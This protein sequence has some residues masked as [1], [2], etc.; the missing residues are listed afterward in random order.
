MAFIIAKKMCDFNL[1]DKFQLEY[2]CCLFL[3]TDVDKINCFSKFMRHFIDK[4]IPYTS[5]LEM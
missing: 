2:N 4:I 1:D 3:I 5:I